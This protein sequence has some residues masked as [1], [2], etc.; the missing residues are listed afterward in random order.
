[1]S[2]LGCTEQGQWQTGWRDRRGPDY[3]RIREQ[4]HLL[5]GQGREAPRGS[6]PAARHTP[7]TAGLGCDVYRPRGHRHHGKQTAGRFVACTASLK[8]LAPTAH[9]CLGP[10]RGSAAA[11][12]LVRTGGSAAGMPVTAAP[13]LPL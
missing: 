8:S 10:L 9:G 5:Q 4:T 1:M 11:S 2:G 7:T 3:I 13:P 12:A 6:P